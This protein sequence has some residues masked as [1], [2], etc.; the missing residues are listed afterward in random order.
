LEWLRKFT[1]FRTRH[2]RT[3]TGEEASKFLQAHLK[4]V[5]AQANINDSL[6]PTVEGFK[7]SGWGQESVVVK[8]PGNEDKEKVIVGAHLDST[9]FLPFL[10]APGAD[11]DASGTTS[12]LGAFHGLVGLLESGWSVEDQAAVEFHWYSA[13]EGGLLGSKD[14]ARSY[15]SR[16]VQVRGMVQIDMTAFVDDENDETIGIFEDNVNPHLT[17]FMEKIISTYSDVKSKRTT[18]G[19]GCSDHASWNNAGAPAC[20]ITENVMERTNK[21]IHSGG[22]TV[23]QGGYSVKHVREFSKIVAAWAV[24]LAGW[25]K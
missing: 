5:I 20:A 14:V 23:D 16:G 1:A 6:R 3:S 15:V 24:E 21:R 17:D 19:Y 12:I 7:H 13:E 18:C 4:E 25:K 2:Y 8:F 10:P 11:D 22:D 9:N